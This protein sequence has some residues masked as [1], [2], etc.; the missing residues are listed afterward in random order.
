MAQRCG[1]TGFPDGVHI[2]VDEGVQ[3][4]DQAPYQRR[5]SH[6]QSQSENHATRMVGEE[7]RKSRDPLATHRVIQH[8]VYATSVRM[9]NETR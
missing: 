3:Q 6:S 4:V 2:S 7:S 5:V 8:P 1:R 9:G